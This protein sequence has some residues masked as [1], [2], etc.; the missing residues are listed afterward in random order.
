MRISPFSIGQHRNSHAL[1]RSVWRD[2]N[3]HYHEVVERCC[4][5][6]HE[7]PHTVLGQNNGDRQIMAPVILRLSVVLLLGLG[8]AL[9]TAYAE[10]DIEWRY[11]AT[12]GAVTLTAN[13]LGT[14][15]RVAFYL[16]RGFTEAAIRP[17]ARACGFSFGM[18]NHGAAALIA[19]LADWHA[20][21][22]VGQRIALRLPEAWDADWEK[23]GVSPAARIAFRWA[24]FQSENIF[25]PGDWIMGMATL[26]VPPVAPFRLVAHYRDDR[27]DH[28]IVID[29]LVCGG[30]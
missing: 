17:Y 26:A 7:D 16:G 8:L 19:R 25:E 27:G 20:I 30:D 24:Q 4:E 6:E 21:D 9:P 1:Y 29:K 18:R 11:H 15:S 5:D 14:A 2:F 23:S 3:T 28:E 13:P 22:A 10:S 12:Q